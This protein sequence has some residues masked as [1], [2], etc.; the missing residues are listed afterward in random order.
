VSALHVIHKHACVGRVGHLDSTLHRVSKYG[1]SH[2]ERLCVCV[3]VRARVCI[4]VCVCVYTCA[5]VR[6]CV[7]M[8]ACVRVREC[9]TPICCT[10][11]VCIMHPLHV[12]KA[13]WKNDAFMPQTH[14]NPYLKVA[15][16]SWKAVA[17]TVICM[18][19]G[20]CSAAPAGPCQDGCAVKSA[21]SPTVWCGVVD[22]SPRGT[23]C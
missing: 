22:T 21:L 10:A 3:C 14:P 18:R 6:V 23:A 20:A 8:C 7:R 5:C 2:T 1:A 9:R 19:A 4:Y 12:H 13:S 11:V 16:G 15:P 17:C